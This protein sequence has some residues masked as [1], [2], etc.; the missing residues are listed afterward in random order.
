[1]VR[2]ALESLSRQTFPDFEVVVV[3]DGSTDGTGE[4]LQSLAEQDHR[5]R[6]FTR[7]PL[8]IVPALEF[9]RSQARGRYLARMDADDGAFAERF[10]RQMELITSDRRMVLCGT[11]IT[12]FP[13][14]T[15][16]D[17]ALRYE[18]WINGLTTHDALVRD[19]FVE[20]TIPHPTFLLRSDVVDLVGGYR[21]MGWPEDYDLALRLWEGGGR[22][23][24]VPEVLLR[25]R[26]S[27]ERLSRTHKAYSGDAFR[28]CKVHFLLRT[29][30]RKGRRV[31]VWGAGPVGKAF[32]RELMAQGGA[33][34]AFVD[35]DP[36]KV[37]QEIYGA[38]VMLPSEALGFPDAFSVA[39]VG[40]RGGRSEIREALEKGGRVETEDFVAVA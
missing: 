35:L 18:R 25:W 14:E 39:A 29:H 13:R 38:R 28:R 11:G 9:A 26:E 24:K 12:Y 36:R 27:E 19:L 10:Q 33:F 37:G 31:L 22:F 20:C 16:R 15:I 7:E 23:G 1:V 32:A 34:L 21:D 8:G 30:L 17:G 4:V 6:V 5:I 40:K 3:D 2:N